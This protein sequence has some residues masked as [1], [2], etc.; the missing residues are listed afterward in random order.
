M[1]QSLVRE[2]AVLVDLGVNLES[3]DVWNLFRQDLESLTDWLVNSLQKG[4]PIVKCLDE[5][6]CYSRNAYATAFEIL[7][8][9]LE[10]TGMTNQA[11]QELQYQLKFLISYLRH[12]N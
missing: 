1:V 7:L 2:N 10:I 6:L 11:S 3:V 5:E 12:V 8:S 9:T 4:Q